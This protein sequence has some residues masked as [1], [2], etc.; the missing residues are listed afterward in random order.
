MLGFLHFRKLLDVQP[1]VKTELG[2]VGVTHL[3]RYLCLFLQ[4][5]SVGYVVPG[6]TKI[7]IQIVK[8]QYFTSPC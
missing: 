7:L 6:K 1:P 3:G 8:A 2:D 4:F 5:Q